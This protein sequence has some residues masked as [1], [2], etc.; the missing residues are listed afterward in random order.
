MYFKALPKM[1]YP[2]GQTKTIV[3]DI[4]RRVHLD[5]YF[6]NRLNL[7]EYY[8]TDGDTPEIVAD[9]FYGSVKYHWLVLV[10]N[11]IIDVQREW[12]LSQTQIV[13]YVDDKYGTDNRTDLHHYVMDEDKDVIVDWDATL[14]AKG[15]YLA[16]T[17]L[18]Y[19]NDLNDKKRPILL[20]H[21]EFLRD[22]TAQYLR[23]V[24]Q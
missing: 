22:I 18:E 8:I 11:N 13:A 16:V 19:E 3:P 5:K 21:K 20:L 6:Q 23:L 9:K 1:F 14:V 15:S 7:L 17:N 2:Y 4:F 10:A 12:P 24:K